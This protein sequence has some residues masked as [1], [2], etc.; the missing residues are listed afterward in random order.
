M[1]RRLLSILVFLFWLANVLKAQDPAFSQLFNNRMYLNPAFTGIDQGHRVSLATRSLWRNLPRNFNTNKLSYDYRPCEFPRIG[2]GLIAMQNTE[3]DGFLQSTELGGVFAFHTPYS[4][5][6]M[7]KAQSAGSF[8]FALQASYISRNID[9]DKL[10]FG[11]QL[12]PVLGVVNPRTAQA[13]L[14]FQG[15]NTYD[16]AAGFLWRQRLY[17]SKRWDMTLHAGFA[18][19]HIFRPKVG[20]VNNGIM[21]VKY[22]FHTGLLIP[23]SKRSYIIPAIRY[24]NQDSTQIHNIFDANVMYLNGKVFG[25]LSYRFN[26]F[27]NYIKNTDAVMFFV[28]YEIDFSKEADLRLTYSFDTNFKGVSTGNFYT[29]EISVIFVFS[30][31]CATKI[32]LMNKNICDYEG[33]G[34]PKIF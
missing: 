4:F 25:G 8:S 23:L 30:K 28:G 20:L 14:N 22:T 3:G 5:K 31:K 26:Q 6:R 2:V 34:L 27:T 16:F 11:D 9:W 7:R 10:V 33:K 1:V 21:P 13:E 12:D 19:H 17:L 18:A 24:M 15:I 29:H 32:G